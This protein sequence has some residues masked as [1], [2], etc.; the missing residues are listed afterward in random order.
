MDWQFDRKLGFAKAPKWEGWFCHRCCWNQPLPASDEER[1][2][3][4][5]QIRVEFDKHDCET[6]ARENWRKNSA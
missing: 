3:Q 2:A 6:F 5:V 1:K 4:S